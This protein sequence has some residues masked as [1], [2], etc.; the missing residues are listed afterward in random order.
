[1][2][3]DTDEVQKM[4]PVIASEIASKLLAFEAAS[5]LE[6]T[7]VRVFRRSQVDQGGKVI[8]TKYSVKLELGL[9]L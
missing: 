9:K 1:M 8:T 5:G 6:V 3:I 7:A 2:I 4:A